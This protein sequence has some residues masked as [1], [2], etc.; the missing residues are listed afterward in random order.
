MRREIHIRSYFSLPTDLAKEMGEWP[1]FV[2][3]EGYSVDLGNA[4]TGE[5][6]TVRLSE[7]GEDGRFVAVASEDAGALFDR[8]LGRVLCALSEHSDDLIVDKHA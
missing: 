5:R 8:V 2:N 6:V 1:E 7:N 3:G 4:A